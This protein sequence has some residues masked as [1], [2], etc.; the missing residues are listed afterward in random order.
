MA[1]FT[2]VTAT[3]IYKDGKPT[4]GLHHTLDQAREMDARVRVDT[5]QDECRVMLTLNS[6]EPDVM[7]IAQLLAELTMALPPGASATTSSWRWTGPV[8]F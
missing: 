6:T 3:G 2:I 5:D 7:L 1:D 8:P 4:E